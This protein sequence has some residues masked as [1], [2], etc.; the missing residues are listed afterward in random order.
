M[1]QFI[2]LAVGLVVGGS[3]AAGFADRAVE[4]R[5]EPQAVIL[6]PANDLRKPT[7]SGRRLM[8]ESDRQGHFQVRGAG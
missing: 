3:Y 2:F 1:R 6:E 5:P 4:T 7:T 8:L